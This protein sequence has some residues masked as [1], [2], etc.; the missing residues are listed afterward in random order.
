[1]RYCAMP[2]ARQ[3]D[4][5]P[6]P[7]FL[8]LEGQ[9]VLI[10]GDGPEAAAK[11]RLLRG[12][13]AELQAIAPDHAPDLAVAAHECGANYAQR[14]FQDADLDGVALCFV[15]LRSDV[16]TR[17]VVAAARARGVLVNAVD[18]PELCDFLVP[19]IIDR[20]PVC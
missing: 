9:R 15:A 10:V 13:G 12:R 2:H 7:L 8:T 1:M 4:A 19:A 11:L 3:P 18:W 14:M 6:F 5:A 17:R 16:V 20:A